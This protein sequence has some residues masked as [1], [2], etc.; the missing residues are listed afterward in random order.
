MLEWI[1]AVL[2]MLARKDL[3]PW[4]VQIVEVAHRARDLDWGVVEGYFTPRG[5]FPLLW[6]ALPVFLSQLFLIVSVSVWPVTR[7]S[8]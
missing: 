5:H 4:H 6:Q 1:L 7:A 3:L 8:D 2:V